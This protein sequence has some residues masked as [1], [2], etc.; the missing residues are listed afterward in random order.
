MPPKTGPIERL[1]AW[2][3]AVVKPIY[4]VP[5]PANY[6][7]LPAIWQLETKQKLKL[8]QKHK[9]RTETE[10]ETETEPVMETEI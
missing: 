7:E 6:H 1:W 8:K 2:P 3:F 4:F 9:T 10:T 5:F